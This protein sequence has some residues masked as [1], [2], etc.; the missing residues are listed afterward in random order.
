MDEENDGIDDALVFGLIS[1]YQSKKGG[2]MDLSHL[3]LILANYSKNF[4]DLLL[5]FDVGEI[6]F[7]PEIT[8]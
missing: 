1:M 8:S 2:L 3:F 4:I 7:F 6:P 5:V